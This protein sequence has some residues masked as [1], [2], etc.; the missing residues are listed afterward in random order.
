[1]TSYVVD[2]LRLGKFLDSSFE[3]SRK[4]IAKALQLIQEWVA[5]L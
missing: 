4:T 5:L 3:S 1:M 2:I